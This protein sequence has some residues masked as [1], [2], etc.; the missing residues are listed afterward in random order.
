MVN[1]EMINKVNDIYNIYTINAQEEAAR[2]AL[3]FEEES[4]VEKM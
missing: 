4:K 1:P 2:A 3:L